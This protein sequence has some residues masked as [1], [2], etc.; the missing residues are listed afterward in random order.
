M[1]NVPI[2]AGPGSLGAIARKIPAEAVVRAIDIVGTIVVGG[3]QMAAER[4]RFEQDLERL[5]HNDMTTLDRLL[6]LLQLVDHVKITDD[7]RNH[8]VATIC[9]LA[10]K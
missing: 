5:Q 2:P 6:A 4:Q 9:E 7:A 3:L 8:V 10:L 1:S